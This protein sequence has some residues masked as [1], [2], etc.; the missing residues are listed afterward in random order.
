MY[1]RTAKG[2]LHKVT[3]L[4]IQRQA[5][6]IYDRYTSNFIK[7]Y[8]DRNNLNYEEIVQKL[9]QLNQHKQLQYNTIKHTAL[10]S[11]VQETYTNILRRPPYTH[12]HK[13][14]IKKKTITHFTKNDTSTIHAISSPNNVLSNEQTNF[15]IQIYV[16]QY[17]LWRTRSIG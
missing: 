6:E 2:E 15:V 3:F 12:L 7:E 17:T 9:R 13:W 10:D 16:L 1:G 5:N 8:S 4:D 14:F 11:L